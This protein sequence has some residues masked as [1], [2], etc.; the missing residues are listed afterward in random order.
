MSTYLAAKFAALVPQERCRGE[1]ANWTAG[2]EIAATTP[3]EL[4]DEAAQLAETLV[5]W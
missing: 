4:V 3:A 1:T 5:P 2:T